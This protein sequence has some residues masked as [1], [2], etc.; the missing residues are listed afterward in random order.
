MLYRVSRRAF[1]L[2]LAV[3]AGV[4]IVG[5]VPGILIGLTASLIYL[6]ARLARPTD[7]VLQELAGTHRYHDLGDAPCAETVPG[8]IAYR[9]YA[10]LFL[11][12]AEHFVQR[13]RQLI[14]ASPSRVRVFLIDVQAV[15]EVD[16]TAAEALTRLAD[17]LAQN[18]MSL[19]IARAN[20]PLREILSR[21]GLEEKLGIGAFHPSVH[22]AIEVFQRDTRG[23]GPV[24]AV[25]EAR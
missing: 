16:V 14:A 3:T 9:F 6:L 15:W 4:L 25:G 20:R 5:V 2:A 21:I 19:W 1:W 11:A 17:E 18:G 12:N 22:A 23:E 7:V 13:V 8:L 24:S 10:P